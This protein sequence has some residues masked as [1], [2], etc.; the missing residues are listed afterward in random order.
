MD[1]KEDDDFV[2]ASKEKTMKRSE[3]AV[4]ELAQEKMF[5]EELYKRQ[6]K[7]DT[8]SQE[9]FDTL[10]HELKTPIVTIKAY[11]DLLLSGK[12]GEPTPEQK[13]KLLLVKESTESLVDVIL[14]MLEKIKE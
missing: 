10:S 7:R 1:L 5:L 6:E 12:F 11:T 4:K 13:E 2:K 3:H 14:Q 8:K 9:I